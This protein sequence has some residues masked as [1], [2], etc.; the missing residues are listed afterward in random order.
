MSARPA[1]AVCIGFPVILGEG[2]TRRK[3][4]KRQRKNERVASLIS[5][6][7]HILLPGVS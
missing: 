1:D 7:D 6:A 2:E 3:K 5:R 4:R